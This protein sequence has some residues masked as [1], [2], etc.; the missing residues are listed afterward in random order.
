MEKDLR[1]VIKI[2]DM[3]RHNSKGDYFLKHDSFRFGRKGL[4]MD[5]T[6]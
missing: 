1:E 6:T 4:L 3:C 2:E 5:G